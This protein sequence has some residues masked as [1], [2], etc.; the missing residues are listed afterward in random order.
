MNVV[1]MGTP[2]FACFPLKTLAG[3]HHKVMAVVTGPDK[4]AG[5]GHTTVPGPVKTAALELGLPIYQPESLKD[6]SFIQ[7]M[8]SLGADLFVVIAFRILPENLYRLP[9]CG[10]I[11]IHASLLPKYRGAA[12]IH[13]AVKNG[14]ET[15]GLTSFFLTR[16]VD[17]GEMIAQTAT[18]IDP[19]EICSALSTRLSR[20]AGPFLLETLEKIAEPGFCPLRQDDRQAMPAPKIHPADGLI[21]WRQDRRRIHNHIRAFSERPGAFSY[22]GDL[23]VKILQS[24]LTAEMPSASL[25]PGRL[26]VIDRRLY[27]GAGDGPLGLLRL[28]PEGKRVMDGAAFINGY[29]ITTEHNFTDARKEVKY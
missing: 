14:E 16:K 25:E 21:D 13:H 11:N 12:P 20:L 1:Y 9:R 26:A 22:L 7:S 28:Q 6:E 24:A 8:A 27:V 15:T 17:E 3:S 29:R 10:A 2:E 19:D 18:P 23:K 4:P 5:R